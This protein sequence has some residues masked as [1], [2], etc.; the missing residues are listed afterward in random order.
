MDSD[1][2]IIIIMTAGFTHLIKKLFSSS[3]GLDSKLQFRVHGGNAYI[4]L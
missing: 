1:E 2:Q 4:D 3:V